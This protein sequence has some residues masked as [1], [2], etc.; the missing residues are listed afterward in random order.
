MTSVIID[1][2]CRDDKHEEFTECLSGGEA[3]VRDVRKF[4][5]EMT[6]AFDDSRR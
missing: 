4:G 1:G 6:D 5:D 2:L 3:H